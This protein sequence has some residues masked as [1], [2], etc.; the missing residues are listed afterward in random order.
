MDR[1]TATP[2]LTSRHTA[3]T[4]EERAEAAALVT[5][6]RALICPEMPDSIPLARIERM[7]ELPRQSLQRCVVARG[8]ARRRMAPAVRAAVEGEIARRA[9]VKGRA[10]KDRESSSVG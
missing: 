3:P 9:P 1:V 6:L 8:E 10:K 5:Q 4:A 2:R 7:L